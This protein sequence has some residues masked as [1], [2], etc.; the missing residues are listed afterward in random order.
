MSLLHGLRR[1]LIASEGHHDRPRQR[2]PLRPPH[3][4]NHEI[5]PPDIG[6]A[7]HRIPE[8][9]AEIFGPVVP[10]GQHHA[11]V[12][13]QLDTKPPRYRGRAHVLKDEGSGSWV[14]GLYDA[15]GACGD[16]PQRWWAR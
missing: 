6:Q 9:V 8:R 11:S 15:G 14:D 13:G 7:D 10:L 2:L 1:S 16:D 12:G 3:L 4:H 5:A